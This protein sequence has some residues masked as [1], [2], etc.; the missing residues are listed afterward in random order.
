MDISHSIDGFTLI[1]PKHHQMT[2]PSYKNHLR[3]PCS[4]IMS[5]QTVFYT[6]SKYSRSPTLTKKSYKSEGLR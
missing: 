3:L 5:N 1:L 4:L 2:V 6:V